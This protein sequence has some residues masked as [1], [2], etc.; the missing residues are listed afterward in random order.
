MSINQFNESVVNLGTTRRKLTDL[1][2]EQGRLKEEQAKLIERIGIDSA[3]AS[4]ALRLAGDPAMVKIVTEYAEANGLYE[5]EA[6]HLGPQNPV[7]I[8]LDKRRTA[9]REQLR[10]FVAKLQIGTEID[11]RTLI[12]MT[13]ISKQAEMLQVL[14]RNEAAIDGKTRE[15]EALTTEKNRLED[16]IH[17]LS[18]AAGQLEDLKKD[19]ILAEAV[20]SSALARVDT[21]KS[22]IY[23]AYPIVQ[24]LAEPNMP[25]GYEQPRR[26]YAFAGGMAATLFSFIAW[27]L[28][29]LQYLQ[30]TK[31]RKKSS[32]IG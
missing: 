14:V 10:H 29:W 21:S 7:L 3:G 15:I 19:H 8:N 20:Y 30:T 9:M 2:G 18:A 5:V 26:L 32:S 17:K 4:I 23:G 13:N 25:D 1:V 16:E 12:L 22:D 27:G 31:R 6:K 24:V 11:S 28:A